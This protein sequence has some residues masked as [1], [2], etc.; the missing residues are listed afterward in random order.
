MNKA[1]REL[2]FSSPSSCSWLSAKFKLSS[3][4]GEPEILAIDKDKAV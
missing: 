3:F 2:L 4:S 1:N